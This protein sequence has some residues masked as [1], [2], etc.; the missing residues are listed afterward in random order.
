MKQSKITVIGLLVLTVV[1]IL[2][3]CAKKSEAVQVAPSA[4][5]ATA[6]AVL[7]DGSYFAIDTSEVA[8]DWRYFVEV[9]VKGGKIVSANWSAVNPAGDDKKAWDMAGKYNMVKFGGA[10]AQWYEQAQR[11]EEEF[12]KIQSANLPDAISGVSI[13]FDDFTA[14]AQRALRLGPVTQGAYLDG[15]YYAEE[16]DFGDSGW[17]NYV[18]ILV[19]NG[20]IVNVNWS[21]LD[22]EGRDKKAVALVG[23]YGMIKASGIKKEWH[24]QA[25]AA[26]AYLL[27]TQDPKKIDLKSDGKTDAI[28]GATMAVAEFFT[29]AQKALAPAKAASG[30]LSDGSYFAIDTSEVAPNWRSFVELTVKDGK[31]A[32]ANWSAVNPLGEDKKA[33]DK[34]GRYNMVEFGGAQAEWYEQAQVVENE[35]IKAQS[36]DLPDAVSGVTIHIDEFTHLAELALQNGPT[37]K[38]P[39]QDGEYYAEEPTFGNSG[40]KNYVALLVRGGNIVYVNWSGLDK[41]GQNKKNVASTGGYGM[42]KASAIKKEWH[43]QAQAAEAYLLKTQDPKKIDL[44]SDGKTDAI[45]GATMAV[46]EFFTLVE[47][48]LA[49][50]PRTY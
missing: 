42:I 31:I 21:G 22:R 2:S 41:D 36:T 11:V 29:L 4:P 3:G 10:Q 47:K 13:T 44:K 24:E 39:Y 28:A 32:T 27:K 14:L 38:G 9:S 25:Q 50:G 1:L 19:R 43:E 37:A 6:P 18:S 15:E 46:S 23:D 8:P 33:Y 34:G 35:L 45:A 26:E 16:A 17:K 12:I 30:P 5:G 7:A 20:N 40:W 49:N 48:A